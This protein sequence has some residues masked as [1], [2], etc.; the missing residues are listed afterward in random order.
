LG[1]HTGA[2]VSFL[3]LGKHLRCFKR[4]LYV[5]HMSPKSRIKFF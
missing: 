5:R 3:I 2:K 4:S 1:N